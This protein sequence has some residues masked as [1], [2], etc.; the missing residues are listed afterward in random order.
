MRND[1]KK[2][3]CLPSHR[4]VFRVD[5]DD[6][7]LG[8][9]STIRLRKRMTF[10]HT[11][12]YANR[13]KSICKFI[14]SCDRIFLQIK[15]WEF[16]WKF[17]CDSF[18]PCVLITFEIWTEV[19]STDS[20]LTIPFAC[21][22]GI[23]IPSDDAFSPTNCSSFHISTSFVRCVTI[24][25]FSCYFKT[26]AGRRRYSYKNPLEMYVNTKETTPLQTHGSLLLDGCETA[27]LSSTTHTDVL[28]FVCMCVWC[29]VW[30]F[31]GGGVV[32]TRV[33]K[34]FS[35]R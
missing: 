19:P 30:T 9:T 8:E 32:L 14:S 7:V 5:D 34:S 17:Y 10:H 6:M 26:V 25:A 2:M 11:P 20:P 35:L 28:L 4:K 24:C 3:L 15:K 23:V 21:L 33:H 27:C 18:Y 16:I 22:N 12:T 29:V 1:H 31:F 13:E